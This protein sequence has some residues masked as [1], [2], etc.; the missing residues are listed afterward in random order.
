MT[1]NLALDGY[2]PAVNV[3]GDAAIAVITDR[4][5]GK[6]KVVEAKR[7]DEKNNIDDT[8]GSGGHM[9]C[10]YLVCTTG[11]ITYSGSRQFMDP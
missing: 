11:Y 5:F 8:V 1:I 10:H 2:G 3:S 7:R 9:F 4:L 6:K